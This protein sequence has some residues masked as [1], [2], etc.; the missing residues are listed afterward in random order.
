MELGEMGK[1][2]LETRQSRMRPSSASNVH[3]IRIAQA[4]KSVTA[5]FHFPNRQ[6]RK[7]AKAACGVE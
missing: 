3:G 1:A 4:M 5:K 7:V 2:F 6:A